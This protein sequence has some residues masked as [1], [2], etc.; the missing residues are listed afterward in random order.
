MDRLWGKRTGRLFRIR[1]RRPA[2]VLTRR[3]GRSL[4][5]PNLECLDRWDLGGRKVQ[6]PRITVR[7]SLEYFCGKTYDARHF[8]SAVVEA[9]IER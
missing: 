6:G 4:S 8:G 3:G 5:L 1:Q 9:I 2:V 7:G